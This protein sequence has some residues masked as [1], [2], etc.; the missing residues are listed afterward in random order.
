MDISGETKIFWLNLMYIGITAIPTLFLLF[1]LEFTHHT[2]WLTTRRLLL[3]SIQPVTGLLLV[4]TNKYHHLFFLSVKTVQESDFVRLELIR[5]PWHFANLVYSYVLIGIAFFVLSQATLRSSPL[6]LSQYRLIFVSSLLPWGASVYSQYKFSQLDGLDLAPLTFGV[7]GVIFAFAIL[8][9]H[10]MDLIPVARS[11]LIENMTDGIL[12][13]DEQNRILDINPA[14]GNFFENEVSFYIGKTA[15]E[16]FVEWLG[17]VDPFWEELETHKEVKVSNDPYRYLDL[18]VT[19]LYDR[20][21]SLNG[22]LMVFRD[23]TE[24]KLV[25]K[26]LRYV[27]EHQ[28]ARL[29]EIGL[30]QSKLR[31]QAIRD[32]LTKLFNR[33]Y[34]EET[35]DREL[36][37]AGREDYSVCII[38]ID[39]DHFKKINDTYGH[40]A[41]DTVL[42]AIADTLSEETRRGDFACRYG[43]EE[44]VIVL[45]NINIDT[46]CER[47]ESLRNTLNLLYVPYE[48]YSLNVTISMGIACYP[49]HGQSRETILRAAD[50]A[51]YAAKDAGR[52]HILSYD[53]LK[54]SERAL[55]D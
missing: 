23:I 21:H 2:T 42:K 52:D 37:R 50:K 40:E 33:R 26:R 6:Y 30:L 32:S 12:V 44:F 27:N 36:A 29:I 43:G 31:E 5:G 15:G 28:Q 4:W 8:R 25:E 46:A 38:M 51:L 48:I 14:M 39:L 47:A 9:T 10:F 24:R 34:L 3:F 17:Q 41:G 18:R 54:L 22:R 11:Y 7:S 20:K 53:Q 16:V 45:P 55:E 13:L 1:V 49:A 35:L 19:P